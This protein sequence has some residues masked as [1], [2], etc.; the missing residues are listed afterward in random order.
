MHP[1]CAQEVPLCLGIFARAS[2]SRSVFKFRQGQPLLFMKNLF[3]VLVLGF[4]VVDSVEN[5]R[6]LPGRLHWSSRQKFQLQCS[7]L[8]QRATNK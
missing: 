2:T 6:L 4:D 5:E 7:C 8:C 1:S 3:F